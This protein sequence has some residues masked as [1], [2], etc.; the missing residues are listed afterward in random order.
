MAIQLDAMVDMHKKCLDLEA[1]PS[2]LQY[3]SARQ[4][5]AVQQSTD[6]HF[7]HTEKLLNSSHQVCQCETVNA[8]CITMPAT[9][10]AHALRR[11]PGSVND[12][13]LLV[14]EIR[15]AALDDLVSRATSGTSQHGA[16]ASIADRALSCLTGLAPHA[17]DDAAGGTVR[18]ISVILL[19]ALTQQL[20]TH[21]IAHGRLQSHE[22]HKVGT[23]AVL[24]A[25][26][27]FLLLLQRGPHLGTHILDA[28][29]H[30]LAATT[31]ARMPA[32]AAGAVLEHLQ[33]ALLAG[34]S[35]DA[36]LST[37]LVQLLARAAAA[38]PETSQL[39]YQQLMQFVR[40]NSRCP[41]PAECPSAL[42]SAVWALADAAVPMPAQDEAESAEMLQAERV[43]EELLSLA[44]SAA[45]SGRNV[46]WLAAPMHAVAQHVHSIGIAAAVAQALA[47]RPC[48]AIEAQLMALLVQL[49]HSNSRAD[50]SD[51]G[52]A[53]S[54]LELKLLRP[55]LLQRLSVP[56]NRRMH[57][58]AGPLRPHAEAG[59]ERKN[60]ALL[61]PD[62][63]STSMH[64]ALHELCQASNSACESTTAW[65][66]SLAEH[67]MAQL[68]AKQRLRCQA[69]TQALQ[70]G[71]IWPTALDADALAGAQETSSQAEAEEASRL[72]AD[73]VCTITMLCS[74]GDAGVKRTAHAALAAVACAQPHAV[75]HLIPWVLQD[76]D[77]A[78]DVTDAI[79]AGRLPALLALLPAVC[80][81]PA[82][83]RPF[84]AIAA[85]LLAERTPARLQALGVRLLLTYWQTTGRG[86][87][88]LQRAISACGPVSGGDA[89]DSVR[90]DL[91]VRQAVAAATA[92]VARTAPQRCVDVI[93]VVGGM[94]H[95][96]DDVVAAM[97]L[98]SIFWMCYHVCSCSVPAFVTA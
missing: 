28:F 24:P 81:A 62:A 35:A 51:A 14:Q 20:G 58:L 55:Q 88:A 66:S 18:A 65:L 40:L 8:A 13:C 27:P 33:P 84:Q 42:Q 67:A 77:T 94:L 73:I 5:L 38:R 6:A 69:L 82:L 29:A 95:D 79:T 17:A 49:Q 63:C 97:A 44:V 36:P 72:P 85:Q 87:P 91:P 57:A 9:W 16:S 56:A 68:P 32:A 52:A 4:L 23:E 64:L 96:N 93:A 30:L 70:N 31:S 15:N 60:A 34:L 43:C 86:W 48:V 74:H 89:R 54:V 59:S 1:L 11:S 12:L 53:S 75:A 26:Y 46:A 10:P 98:E 90:V 78:L 92:A 45:D 47:A 3:G 19:H 76:I 7:Q 80:T 37:G 22:Y 21:V 25:G 39:A 61:C 2:S 71:Q 83:E 50:H 41:A